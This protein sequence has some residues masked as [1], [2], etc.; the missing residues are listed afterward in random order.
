MNTRPRPST[1]LQEVLVFDHIGQ[2]PDEEAGR[3]RSASVAITTT[4][5]AGAFGVVLGASAVLIADA[6]PS[7]PTTV[8][9]I[10]QLAEPTQDPYDDPLPSAPAPKAA[11]GPSKPVAAPDDPQPLTTPPPDAI[12]SSSSQGTGDPD[13]QGTGDGDGDG[14]PCPG[15]RCGTG[16][17]GTGGG[18]GGGVRVFHH[19]EL[20]VKRRVDPQWPAAAAQLG[21]GEQR[22][23]A[24]VSIDEDGVPYAVDVE[25]CPKI[26]HTPT[27]EALLRWRWYPPKDGKRKIRAATTIAITY[28]QR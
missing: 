14:D 24:R 13:G 10:A 12:V 2:D 28:R 1:I 21:L 16:G 19:S 25:E 5:L 4:L 18:G 8:V 15:G 11:G 27:R 17:E 22:C 26:F 7:V 20:E 9:T 3:R 23:I 6:G